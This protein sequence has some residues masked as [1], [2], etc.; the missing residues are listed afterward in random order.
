MADDK[1][2]HMTCGFCIAL[3]A[4]MYSPKFGLT[5]GMTAG[6]AKEAYDYCSYGIFDRM[7][8]LATWAGAVIGAA[9]AWNILQI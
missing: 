9:L 3:L 7:D 8:M 6:V 2:L 5:V 1:K 4:G